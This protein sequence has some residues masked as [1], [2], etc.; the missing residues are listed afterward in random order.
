MQRALQQSTKFGGQSLVTGAT[1]GLGQAVAR[2]LSKLDSPLVL[3]TRG[4]RRPL[5]LSAPALVF[6]VDFADL[7]TLPRLVEQLEPRS[8]D[9]VVLNAGVMTRSSRA[10]SQGLESMFGVNYLAT[11]AFLRQLL[12]AERLRPAASTRVVIVSS[13]AHRSAAP[14][15][16][17]RLGAW[18]DFGSLTGMR[19][20]AHSKLLLCA[21]ATEL[22]RRLDPKA[23]CVWSLCP[24]PVNSR[25]A[26]EAPRAVQPALDLVMRLGF[27]SPEA[28]ARPVVA[29]GVHPCFEGASGHYFHVEECKAVSAQASDPRLGRDLWEASEALLD[30]LGHGVAPPAPIYLRS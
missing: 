2:Q 26:R 22:A 13:E 6:P 20:Y 17:S 16:L 21:F 9:L 18:V 25:I 24:G 5:G 4:A 10:T 7:S 11:F 28:A 8:L 27:R 30:R 23:A 15:D 19:Q 3:P 29:L 1:S 14:L 12:A